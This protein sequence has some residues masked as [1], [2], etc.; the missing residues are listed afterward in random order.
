MSFDSNRK[1]IVVDNKVWCQYYLIIRLSS[2][3]Y[4]LDL[5]TKNLSRT[6]GNL[7]GDNIRL[8][9]TSLLQV[10]SISLFNFTK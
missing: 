2:T 8:L 3:V 7:S 6:I 9:K 5:N 10:R 4:L 1:H